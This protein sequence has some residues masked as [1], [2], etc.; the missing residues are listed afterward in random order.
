MGEKWYGI[1]D[2]SGI[3]WLYD[4]PEKARKY[5]NNGPTGLSR[6]GW[7]GR[8]AS[9]NIGSS[10]KAVD[11]NEALLG[12]KR[13]M[14]I[15]IIS[16]L[17]KTSGKRVEQSI[18]RALQNLSDEN[19]GMEFTV[20]DLEN[21]ELIPISALVTIAKE[22]GFKSLLAGPSL[23]VAEY[24]AKNSIYGYRLDL[25]GDLGSM[26]CYWHPS[27]VMN[28]ETVRMKKT[29]NEKR[30]MKIIEESIKKYIG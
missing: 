14:L 4:S 10:V 29:V 18:M 17:S 24:L 16:F 28:P 30:L 15:K 9:M 2:G 6:V 26:I 23:K 8:V 3:A 7:D 19:G 25:K 20:R 12:K 21:N 11:V 22:N 1:L 27:V 5:G 13:D